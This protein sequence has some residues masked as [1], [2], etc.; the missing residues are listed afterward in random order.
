MQEAGVKKEQGQG[1]YLWLIT[2]LCRTTW[3]EELFCMQRSSRLHLLLQWRDKVPTPPWRIF[4]VT[5]SSSEDQQVLKWIEIKP[6]NYRISYFSPPPLLKEKQ[7][8]QVS[9]YTVK[10]QTKK[11]KI[12]INQDIPPGNHFTFLPDKQLAIT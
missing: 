4:S 7:S 8:A 11:I 2:A 3:R 12:K 5:I 10:L 1:W 6:K 9:K